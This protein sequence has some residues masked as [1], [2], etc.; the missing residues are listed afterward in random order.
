MPR[1]LVVAHQ[2]AT[3]SELV[4]KVRE[5][6]ASDPEAEFSLLVPAM[7]VNHL[8]TWEEGESRLA[9]QRTA[10]TARMYFEGV[11]AT[12]VRAEIGDPSPLQAIDDELRDR[13][14]SYDTIVISTLPPNW[15]KWLAL[16]LPTR[17]QHRFELPV[18]HIIADP[19]VANIRSL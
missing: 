2:T 6:A 10:D 13:P 18:V 11:G 19:Q 16:D 9:A 3:S 14:G 4:E 8:L 1:Y 15:S 17:V 5:L 7:P 12:V